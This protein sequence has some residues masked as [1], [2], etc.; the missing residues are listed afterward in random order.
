MLQIEKISVFLLMAGLFFA[1]TGALFADNNTA[2]EYFRKAADKEWGRDY[3]AAASLFEEAHVQADDPVLKA[4]AL[5]NVARCYR[6]AQR[7]GKEFDVLQGLIAGHVSRINYTAV[8]QRQYEIA[9]LFFKGYREVFVSWLP[10]I[11]KEDRTAELFQKVLENAPCA[12]DAPEIRLALGR[13]YLDDQK[14][15]EAAEEFKKT[16]QL[17][18]ETKEAKYAAL[19]LANVYVQQAEN[20]DGDGRYA[21]EAIEALNFYLE[22]HPNDP[23]TQWIRD[24][25]KKVHS[26]IAKRYCNLGDFYRKKGKTETAERYYALVLTDYPNTPEAEKAEKQLAKLDQEFLSSRKQYT[27]EEKKFIEKTLPAE[28][29]SIITHPEESNGR[30]LLPIRN[31]RSTVKAPQKATFEREAVN[32]DD[33]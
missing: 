31:V 12:E 6:K 3:L 13:I 5:M 24:S 14:P 32:D 8:V 11:K 33:L 7:Y 26:Y 30:W 17:Y 18:P 29:Q 25:L 20:G 15:E 4:N 22:K 21:K 16:I 9:H 28:P 23:E 27:P 10:F 1:G 19:E 2:F